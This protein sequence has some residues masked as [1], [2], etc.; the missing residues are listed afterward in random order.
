EQL[1]GLVGAAAGGQAESGDGDE[2]Q[3]RHTAQRPVAEAIVHQ[4]GA[5][6]GPETE[7]ECSIGAMRGRLFGLLL[8]AAIS[9]PA[10][11]S[12]APVLVMGR[13][14]HVRRATDRFLPAAPLT[15][16][17]SRRAVVGPPASRT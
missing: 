6:R 4:T 15:P 10:T 17:P 14:G 16:A 8:A 12:A 7:R 11:A 13:N 9:F 2:G 1:G 5:R 3:R